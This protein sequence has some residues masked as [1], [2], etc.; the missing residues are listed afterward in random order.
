MKSLK[1]LLFLVLCLALTACAPKEKAPELDL[2]Y[3]AGA[4]TRPRT[5]SWC[6]GC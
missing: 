4:L 3:I 6:L 1:P 2:D 5:R